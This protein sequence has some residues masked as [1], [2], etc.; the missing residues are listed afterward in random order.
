MKYFNEKGI[1]TQIQERKNGYFLVTKKETYNN[2]NRTG[3]DGY[4]SIQRIKEI[5]AEYKAPKGFEQ[6]TFN[7]PYGEVVE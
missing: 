4:M 3:S 1:E 7:D 6:F 2:P 5:G